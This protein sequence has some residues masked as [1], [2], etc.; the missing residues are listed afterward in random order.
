MDD[1]FRLKRFIDAQETA[2]F[3][4]IEELRAGRKRT[5][6]MWFIFPQ[7]AGLG[8]SKPS[9]YYAINS[10]DEARAYLQSPIL[11]SRLKSTTCIV[12]SLVGHKL[13]DIFGP[14][15]DA[16]FCSSMTLFERV[17]MSDKNPYREAIDRFCSGQRDQRTLSLI[18][19][20]GRDV[21]SYKGAPGTSGR[22]AN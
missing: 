14:P 5:H 13:S 17:A 20:A 12:N 4:A 7:F 9:R 22:P 8:Y 16:K 11:G 21:N 3:T 15:D 2:F 10:E 6:W 19:S 1:P 18:E